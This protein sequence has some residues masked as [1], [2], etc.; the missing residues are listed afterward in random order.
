MTDTKVDTR[1]PHWDM[2]TVFPSLDSSEFATAYDTLL[3][4]IAELVAL[5]DAKGVRKTD[6]LAVDDASVATFEDMLTRLNDIG[7]RTREITSYLH[8]FITTE[9]QNDAAQARS[10]CWVR[11]PIRRGGTLSTRSRL[12]ESKGL[13]T[14][15]R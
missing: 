6:G 9:A 5:A 1:L 3:K 2:T 11:S 8:S 7:D 12:T 14:R 10:S 13:R 4:S 15:R